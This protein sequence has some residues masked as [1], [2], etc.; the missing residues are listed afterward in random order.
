MAGST[1]SR[2][3]KRTRSGSLALI[4]R[5][6]AEKA[7]RPST[8]LKRF[9]LSYYGVASLPPPERLDVAAPKVGAKSAETKKIAAEKARAPRGKPGV[10][11]ARNRGRP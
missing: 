8:P 11:W 10:L 4:K 5:D 1:R 6:A 3:T 2:P 9:L 7:P